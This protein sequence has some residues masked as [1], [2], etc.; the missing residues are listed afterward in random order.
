MRRRKRR[1]GASI[2]RECDYTDM[3]C[4]ELGTRWYSALTALTNHRQQHAF[5]RLSGLYWKC[6]KF[7][8]VSICFGQ[9]TTTTDTRTKRSTTAGLNGKLCTS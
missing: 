6:F 4:E 3:A 1:R 7:F 5:K 2:S 9:N 8:N